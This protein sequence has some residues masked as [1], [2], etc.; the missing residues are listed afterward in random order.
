MPDCL[1]CGASRWRARPY[2][3]KASYLQCLQ[4]NYYVLV[5]RTEDDRAAQFEVAQ[6]AYYGEDS[7]PPS[8]SFSLLNA[9]IMRRRVSVVRSHLATGASII[10]AGPGNGDLVVALNQL[11]FKTTAV[12]HSDTLA[13]RLG[14]KTPIQVLVGDFAD[15]QLPS[16]SFDAYC[17]FHV[18]EH[19][20]DFKNHLRVAH[21]CVKPGGH[22]FIATPNTLGWE[23]R[24]PWRLSPN[25]DSAHFQLFSA[26]ALGAALRE[27]GWDLE[28]VVT[29]SY[30]IAWLRVA[31]KIL[32][33]IKG[34]DQEASA[35]LYAR[36]ENQALGRAIA[37]FSAVTLPF[38]LLQEALAGGNE[39][40]LVARR[41]G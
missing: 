2:T 26:K 41:R 37:A 40:F 28:Q 21:D 31:T 24:L 35:G 17:S 33:R 7:A 25:Y 4:C 30:A 22:A 38:R 14:E 1:C 10:E 13:R 16:A 39:L 36:S 19:V 15:Q 8:S 5:K 32:R 9:E 11:G 27:T 3:D 20:I 29:P 6:Q 18:I 34:Q 23:H 12:E